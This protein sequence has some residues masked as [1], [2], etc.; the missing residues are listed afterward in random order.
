MDQLLWSGRLM[1]TDNPFFFGKSFT[2]FSNEEEKA[3]DGVKLIPFLLEDKIA[4][5]GGKYEKADEL[6]AS[7]VVVDGRLI[8]GQNPGSATDIGKAIL[9]AIKQ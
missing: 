1:P 2:G 6:W 8:T 5:L 7:K 9:K 4:E 3:V